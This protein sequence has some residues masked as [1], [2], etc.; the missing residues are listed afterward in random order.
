MHIFKMH[1]VTKQI[2]TPN[3]NRSKPITIILSTFDTWSKIHPTFF[4]YESY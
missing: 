4:I 3:R 1:S 2:Y